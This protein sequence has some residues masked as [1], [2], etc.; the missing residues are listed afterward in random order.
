MRFVLI[1]AIDDDFNARVLDVMRDPIADQVRARV[2]L[3]G[4][5]EGTD[6]DEAIEIV[7]FNTDDSI[8]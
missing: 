3:H 5:I 7:D 6:D 8:T 2:E 1:L 4:G